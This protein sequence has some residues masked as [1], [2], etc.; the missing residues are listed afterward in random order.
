MKKLLKFILFLIILVLVIVGGIIFAISDSTDETPVDKFDSTVSK[1]DLLSVLLKTSIENMATDYDLDIK[2]SED[3]LNQLVYSFIKESLNEQYDP[4]NGTTDEQKYIYS[5]FSVPENIPVIGGKKLIVKSA[6]AEIDGEYVSLNVPAEAFGFVKSRLRLTFKVSTTETK[7]ILNIK[8]LKFGKIN[9]AGKLVKKALVKANLKEQVDKA[10]KD[11]GLPFTCNFEDMALEATKEDF[12]K[13]VQDLLLKDGEESDMKSVFI[14]LLLD[15]NAS[16]LG[17][18]MYE[19]KFGVKIDLSE[20]RVDEKLTTPNPLVQAELTTD[21]LIKNKAQ[22]FIVN[23]LS[24]SDNFMTFSELEI[25]QLVYNQTNKY[26]GFGISTEILGDTKFEFG[27]KSIEVD[28]DDTGKKFNLNIILDINGLKTLAVL[29]GNVTQKS[30]TEVSIKLGDKLKVGSLEIEAAFMTDL[31]KTSLGSSDIMKF[32]DSTNSLLID[33]K[34][35]EQFMDETGSEASKINVTGISF[36]KNGLR[37]DVEY[38]D[39]T[40]ASAIESA[41]TIVNDFLANEGLDIEAFG[42]LSAEQK[43]AV[44]DLNDKIGDLAEIINDP[45]KELKPEDTDALVN[46]INNLDSENQEKLFQQIS[47]SAGSDP[48]IQDLYSQLF[49]LTE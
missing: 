40:L 3:E 42:E 45:S 33:A 13:W 14:K 9:L 1:E 24:S 4:K 16:R 12:S 19:N 20:L 23:A 28:I 34:V 10:I 46:A 30:A 36:V 22:T 17:V 27:V 5:D 2:L 11:K 26:E 8:E 37:I 32:D 41:K 35:F 21:T 6:Y 29:E 39:P 44:E 15:P 7:Y 43:A 18:G 47:D 48:A 49:G 31:L 25:S 38:S